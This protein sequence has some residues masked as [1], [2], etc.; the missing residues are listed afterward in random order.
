M[1][2]GALAAALLAAVALLLP[3]PAAQWRDAATDALMRLLPRPGGAPPVVMVEIDE[4]ALA[5][6]PWPWPRDRLA[7]LVGALAAAGAGAVA[8]DIVLD[9]PGEG[10]AALAARLREA[11]GVVGVLAGT[12]APAVAVGVAIIGRPDLGGLPALPGI[13]T[14]ALPGVPA[15]LA[16]LPGSPVRAVPLL[17]RLET[18]PEVPVPGLALAA[19]LRAS[20]TAT[21]LLAEGPP[22][23]MV[24]AGVSLPLPPDGLL[25]L[26]PGRVPPAAIDARR[27]LAGAL[28]D[29]GGRLAVIGVTAPEVAPLRPSVFGDFTASLRLQAEAAGQIAEGWVP[30][31]PGWARF[32]EAALAAGFGL[33]AAATMARRAVAGVAVMLALAAAGPALAGAALRMGPWIA[34]PLLPAIGA[35]AGGLVQGVAEARRLARDRS[36]LLARFASR[37]PGGVADRLLALPEAERLRPERVAAAIVITDITGFS[38]MVRGAEPQAL[39]GVLNAYLAGVEACVVAEGGTLERLIGDSVLAIFG[40]PVAQPDHARRALAAARA[41]DAFAE[42]FRRRPEAVA[43]G[44]GATRIGVAAG[45]VLV[46]E[47]GGS[48]LTWSVCGDAANI[49]ARL[50]ELGKE[51]GRR[52]L[53]TGIDDPSLPPPIGR[54]ALRGFEGRHE[55]R[56]LA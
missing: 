28:P 1:K 43:L 34:D 31:R 12:A 17:A 55:V 14:P 3:V 30:L 42:A 26:H 54:F 44:L 19:V 51:V 48:R 4:A 52:A 47:L 40:A 35:L 24:L 38:T 39:V 32:A 21:L 18:A 11:A 56:P 36:R 8:L 46:G 2:A 27:V 9:Q 10:D 22:P 29:L 15:A 33:V 53:A 37:L 6:A 50:Q 41:I 5:E 7:A 16:A 20:A 13:A 49:A 23:A 45:Q 25:R